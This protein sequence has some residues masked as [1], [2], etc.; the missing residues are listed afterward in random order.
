MTDT[1]AKRA[2]YERMADDFWA[3]RHGGESADWSRI[4]HGERLRPLSG[5][6]RAALERQRSM[7]SFERSR[8][9]FWRLIYALPS[10][11]GVIVFL[12][13]VGMVIMLLGE[14]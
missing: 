6:E 8:E 12:N 14:K 3:A 5:S 10:V 13:L 9:R 1:T 11:I 7:E 2:L 4:M